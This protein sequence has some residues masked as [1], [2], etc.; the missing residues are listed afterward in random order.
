M[1]EF[2]IIRALSEYIQPRLLHKLYADREIGISIGRL[3]AL[4]DQMIA[5][6]VCRQLIET[7]NTG[8][9]PWIQQLRM[10]RIEMSG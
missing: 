2:K 9:C 3:P 4:G 6:L 5:E 1:C 8:I 10:V 7:G